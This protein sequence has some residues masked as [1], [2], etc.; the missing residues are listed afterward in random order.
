MASS[1]PSTMSWPAGAPYTLPHPDYDE[2]DDDALDDASHVNGSA[3]DSKEKMVRRRSSKACD[4]CRKSKC[5]CERTAP[6]AQCR[7]CIMV[8]TECTFLGPSR[9]R[10]P[11][12]GY[13]DAIE[14]RLHQTEALVG[15]LLAAGG[16]RFTGGAADPAA[17]HDDV[18]DEARGRERERDKGG[19]DRDR[20][21]GKDSE[22]EVDERARELVAD[23]MEDPLARAI[24]A[25]INQSPYGPAGR[26][27][28]SGGG[29]AHS[30]GSGAG[31]GS[32][33]GQVAEIGNTHPSHEWMDR[34]TAQM[35]RR[36]RARRDAG[37][38]VGQ[39][40]SPNEQTQPQPQSP[41]RPGGSTP[42]VA[43]GRTHDGRLSPYRFTYPEGQG[44]PQ[45]VRARAPRAQ[46]PAIITALGEY[47][48][49]GHVYPQSAPGGGE[50]RAH[51]FGDAHALP[52]SA[53][54][55]G[56]GYHPEYGRIRALP[57]P[58]SA[59]SD[60]DGRSLPFDGGGEGRR[61]RRRV[62][63]GTSAIYERA[64]SPDA[65]ESDSELDLDVDGPRDHGAGRDGDGDRS[66]D[67]DRDPMTRGRWRP[68]E[69]TSG[70]AMAGLAGAVGQ[71]SLNEDKE[72]RYHGKASG[73][74]L[75]ARR[76]VPAQSPSPTPVREDEREAAR[77]AEDGRNVGGI[78]RFPKAR[79][80]P[81]VPAPEST[82]EWD[83][84][85]AGEADEDGLPTR[86]VQEALLARYFTHVH[87][88][89]PV[90]HKR[91]V[92]EAFAR[93]DGPP[94]LLLLAMY[95]LAARHAPQPTRDEV[96]VQQIMWPAGD[97]FLFRAK[98]LLDSSYASSRASTCAALLLMG[99]REIGIGAM[100]QAW[101]YIGMAVRMAQDL[102]MH[103]D[104][105]GWVRAGVR[106]GRAAEAEAGGAGAHVEGSMEREAEAR[107]ER[108]E[109]D[110]EGRRAGDGKLF[111]AW[112][113][114]E[115]RRIWYACVIM[116]KYVSTYI[117]RP[118]AVFERDFDTS[119]PS[120]SEA[121]EAE[122]WAPPMDAPLSA[123]PRPGRVISCF[124]ASARLASILSQ[125]IQSIYALR[126]PNSR[127]AELLVLDGQLEKWHL[128]LPSH[129]QYDP[130]VR[131]SA[132]EV[133]LPHVLTLHM[134]YWCAVLL[135]HRPF[136]RNNALRN[137]N[138]PAPDEGDARGHAEKSYELCAGAA[139][140]ITSI[141]TLYSEMYTLR[142]CA[143][144]LCYYVFTASIMHVTSLTA[145]P[146]D[147]LARMGLTRCMDAL[148]EMEI[149]WPAAAR[150]L[151]L[152]RGAQASL[153]DVAA[154]ADVSNSSSLSNTASASGTRK[155]PATQ[156]LDDSSF[157][158]PPPADDNFLPFTPQ[159]YAP[160]GNNYGVE[161]RGLYYP[162]TPVS[163]YERWQGQ[164]GVLAFNGAL[165]TAVM[166]P[167]YSTGLV[168]ERQHRGGE[169]RYA[170]PP[171]QQQ[172]WSD[173]GAAPFPQLG[174]GPGYGSLHD[175]SAGLGVPHPTEP[176][177]YQPLH[178][179]YNLY[180][181][182][183]P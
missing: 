49:P 160:N 106:V 151:E 5:K 168:D 178:D 74:H 149:I 66:R 135:L 45:H 141:A 140:H 14:A 24:L 181:H 145:H 130:A 58:L 44:Q 138:S 167:T 41:V 89:F 64:A 11:P 133:P 12:K 122:E 144:F 101:I 119:L 38:R 175:P 174:V 6:E 19:R 47:G 88:S 98:T 36:A 142:Q 117:G 53:G 116:D 99:F 110:G 153:A 100:A 61:L 166:G 7:N 56:S 63:D 147:A 43:Q 65:S 123:A 70:R 28:L 57:L 173:Y 155:R 124:N 59:T 86:A 55:D 31:R 92:M 114:A 15:I 154:D 87:P 161:S 60:R 39:S 71:L 75:L 33:L 159:V 152:L 137:K 20:K 121:E 77:R 164:D 150:A 30:S 93:G 105:D 171:H 40:R 182:H 73:L 96:E 26:V 50:R 102:G 72:V 23:L 27:A 29:S 2:D 84:D 134:Q 158:Q 4:Q 67:R 127:H 95:A 120:E 139:N 132:S 48:R 54:V 13:I 125:I 81:A 97:G 9:K 177:M 34:V 143:V 3:K 109:A 85:G 37:R 103:R 118:L 91:S 136:I 17:L 62:D 104:A 183:G 16:V 169:P 165:S 170:Q 115:R 83:A 68:G 163:P 180:P 131:V 52:L 69:E 157:G 94:P 25:R 10:G 156:T 51:A 80:W 172:Y 126:L 35:L 111:G 8:G 113:I 76:P 46:R 176:Q 1:S 128:A 107:T 78:W 148:Q 18:K 22:R 82:S 21:G 162:Q 179:Q 79:V 129:L 90:V 108:E 32:G 146:N 42:N 112:E